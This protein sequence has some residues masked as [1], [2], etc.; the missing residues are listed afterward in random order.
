MNSGYV[1]EIAIYRTWYQNT[2]SE[3]ET[4]ARVSMF[5]PQW[6]LDMESIENTTNQRIWDRGLNTFFDNGIEQDSN[7][8]ENFL[9]EVETIQGFLCDAANETEIEADQEAVQDFAQQEKVLA[10]APAQSLLDN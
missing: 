7:G 9:A 6:D 2:N 5:H 10:L 1:I 8:F 3:P 4:D